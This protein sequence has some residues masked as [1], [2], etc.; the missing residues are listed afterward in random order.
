LNLKSGTAVVQKKRSSQGK[1][2]CH[3]NMKKEVWTIGH[4]T[5]SLTDFIDLLKSFSIKH[6]G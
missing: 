3:S 1:S 4:S 2:G 6:L 5:R